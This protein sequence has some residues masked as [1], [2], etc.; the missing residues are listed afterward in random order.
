[1]SRNFK[2]VL[3]P[4][5]PKS[6][7]TSLLLLLVANFYANFYNSV[8]NRWIDQFYCAAD[9]HLKYIY[10]AFSHYKTVVF[11]KITSK[12]ILNIQAPS[13]VLGRLQFATTV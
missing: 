1:M 5:Y 7:I 10:L 11:Q 2:A 12:W 13:Q 3:Y 8:H 4:T 9:L 6:I